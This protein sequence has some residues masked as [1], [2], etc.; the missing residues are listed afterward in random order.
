MLL[1][2]VGLVMRSVGMLFAAYLSRTVGAEGM[3]VYAIVTTVYSF[4]MTV[5]S[6]GISLS[7]TRLVAE[8]V[9]EGREKYVGSLIVGALIYSFG[10]SLFA[11]SLM[12]IGA[13]VI[14]GIALGSTEFSS[15]FRVLAAS[16]IPASFSSV[17]VGYF[18]GIK[19]VRYNAFTQITSQ[20]LRVL[21]TVIFVGYAEGRGVKSAML[22]LSLGITVTEI[23]TFLALL[24]GFAFHRRRA[25]LSERKRA[26]TVR[27]VAVNTLPLSFSQYVRSV[28]ITLEHML[29]PKR[30]ILH[31]DSPAKA[32]ADYGTLHG[33]AL[34]C[35]LFA[36]SPLSSFSGLLVPELAE[37]YS[38]GRH[39]RMERVAREALST[40]LAYSIA[41]SVLLWFFSEELGYAVY[42]SYEVGKYISVLATVVPIM[43]LDHVADSMLKGVGDHVYSMWVNITDSL[44]SILLVFILLPRIGIFGY[45]L[46][47]IIMEGYNFLLS[48]T[49]LRKHIR[50]RISMLRSF[51][52]PAVSSVS[53]AFIASLLFLPNGSTA[54]VAKIIPTIAFSVAAAVFF[55]VV[56]TSFADLL[57]RSH[58]I[59]RKAIKNS[60]HL[61]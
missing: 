9:G 35:V 34:P 11:T 4:A 46:V 26:G 30:L 14:S 2:A 47:I 22:A 40:T 41:V 5:A 61:D 3:G 28:L 16:L 48:V 36:M 27:A 59:S 21:C 19:R 58:I 20:L 52:I 18:V 12:L 50:I 32:Y 60:T 44:L 7:V 53:A 8:A 33:M 42:R 51:I 24:L 55:G 57:N 25:V 54:T 38:A 43:Y 6:S 29:I 15:S 10:F 23:V 13:D 56:L 31:G 39:K 1:T 17:I 49:R 37:D 45:A